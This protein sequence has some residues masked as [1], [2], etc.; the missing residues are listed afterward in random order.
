MLPELSVWKS[1]ILTFSYLYFNNCES[2]NR[3]VSLFRSGPWTTTSLFSICKKYVIFRLT[4][5]LQKIKIITNWY[6]LW[7]LNCFNRVHCRNHNFAQFWAHIILLPGNWVCNKNTF[8]DKFF[9]LSWLPLTD[10]DGASCECV[11]LKAVL[12]IVR[13]CR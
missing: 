7:L 6:L 9:M 10:C 1:N 8:C 4:Y 3:D 11:K 13:V 2:D 12:P 5:L